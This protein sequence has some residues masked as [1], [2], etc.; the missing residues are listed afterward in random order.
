MMDACL[1]YNSPKTAGLSRDRLMMSLSVLTL[2]IAR[3]PQK[4]SRSLPFFAP[5]GSSSKRT[6]DRSPHYA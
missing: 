2:C 3:W 5:N 1:S 4:G 6:G